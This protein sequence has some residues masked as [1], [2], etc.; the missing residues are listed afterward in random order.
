MSNDLII[1]DNQEVIEKLVLDGDLSRMSQPQK[2]KYYNAFCKALGLNPLTQPFAIIKFQGKERLYAQKDCTEQLRKLHG[3]SITE[4]TTASLNDVFIVTAKA[5]D[6][7]GKT[8]CSTGAVNIKGLAGDNLANALMKA[9]TKAKRRVTLSICGLGILD[10]SE[11][12]TIKGHTLYTSDEMQQAEVKVEDAPDESE[13][14]LLRQMVHTS[15]LSQEKKQETLDYIDT[16]TNY[17]K[18]E[19]LQLKLED[20]QIGYDEVPNP[21]HKDINKK[22]KSVQS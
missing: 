10:E 5:I 14:E 6:K 8:D 18:Y 11:T 16:I 4:I 20:V 9:E 21:N 22:L 1:Q 7:S 13:K 12:D 3:V 2:V 17:K 19:A 15:T